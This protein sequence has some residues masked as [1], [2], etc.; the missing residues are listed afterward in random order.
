MTDRLITSTSNPRIKK[1]R[2]LTEP[3]ARREFGLC[4]VEGSSEILYAL[5]AKVQIETLFYVHTSEDIPKEDLSLIEKIRRAGAELLEVSPHVLAKLSY[6]AHPEPV[7]ALARIPNTTPADFEQKIDRDNPRGKRIILLDGVEKPGNIGAAL[8][9]IDGAG[10]DGLIASCCRTD[11]ANPNIIRASRGSVFTLPAAECSSE[12]ALAWL[13]KRDCVVF[14]LHP[15]KGESYFE[16]DIYTHSPKDLVFVFG[17][18]HSGLPPFWLQHADVRLSIPMLGKVDSLNIAQAVTLL[19][20]EVLRQ[21][22]FSASPPL[23]SRS[24]HEP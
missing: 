11:L 8:R 13:K 23:N 21:D 4:I 22:A 10:L 19:A 3:R 24:K 5:E 15:E 6:R 14:A 1:A 16:H 17:A 18:E 12:E 9:S 20:Y 7:L 2:S